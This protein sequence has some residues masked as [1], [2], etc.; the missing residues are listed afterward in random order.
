MLDG[1]FCLQVTGQPFGNLPGHP[2]LPKRALNKK[3]QP[4]NEEEQRQKKP[5]QYFFKSPQVQLIK[6]QK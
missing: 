4:H 3:I 5:L 2:V 6:V 1:D